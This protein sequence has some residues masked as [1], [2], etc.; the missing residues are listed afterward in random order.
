MWKQ[1]GVSVALAILIGSSAG[2]SIFAQDQGFVIGI[3]NGIDLIQGIG[4]NGSSQSLVLN[5]TQN[6][7]GVGS[8]F[9][10]QLVSVVNMPVMTSGLPAMTSIA[11]GLM[12]S[13]LV[14]PWTVHSLGDQARLHAL[15]LSAN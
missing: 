8:A 3:G 10:S 1:I 9:G 11:N 12:V 2:A 7:T 15:M 14:S 6:G 4:S 13:G 5:L